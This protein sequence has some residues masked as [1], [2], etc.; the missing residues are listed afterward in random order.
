MSE[1]Q[2][3]VATVVPTAEEK[4]AVWEDFIDIFYEPRA[5]F[6]RRI[7]ANAWWVLLALTV[8][9]T[10]L[11]YAWQHAMGPVL[12]V[13]MQRAAAR[14]MA[15]NPNLTAEQMQRMQGFGRIFAVVGFAVTFPIG[16]LLAALVTWAV[17]KSM[18][19]ATGFAAMLLVVTYAQIVR[20][21]QFLV[22]LVESFVMDMNRLDSV[23]DLSFS[24]ARFLDQ[25]A[26]SST[27]LNL[28]ARVDVFTLWAT[29]LIAIGLQVVAKLPRG[30]A[31]TAAVLV[32]LIAAIPQL[33]GGMFGG[34]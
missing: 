28:A 25:P 34:G 1:E 26:V 9:L 4:S 3:G 2:G 30:K 11:F 7:G 13:E 12:D 5:V 8:V 21:P 31:W 20:V 15:S 24:A 29:A 22:G 17:A 14:A 33:I 19:A 6:Q 27:V 18:D 32:W 23:H 16:V 10:A